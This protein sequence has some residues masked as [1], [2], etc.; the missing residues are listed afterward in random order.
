MLVKTTKRGASHPLLAKNGQ[1]IGFVVVDI[2]DSGLTLK[3]SDINH[4]HIFETRITA[5][6]HWF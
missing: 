5:A 2:V 3:V 4:H 6:I 1:W